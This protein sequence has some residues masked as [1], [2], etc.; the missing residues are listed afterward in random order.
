MKDWKL[1]LALVALGAGGG[2]IGTGVVDAADVGYTSVV[3]LE[4]VAATVEAIDAD[5][6]KQKPGFVWTDLVCSRLLRGGALVTACDVG[7][8]GTASAVEDLPDGA[9]IK[10]Q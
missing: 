10:T 5:V 3:K 4:F 7:G 2:T 6:S 9:R 8:L 1:Y